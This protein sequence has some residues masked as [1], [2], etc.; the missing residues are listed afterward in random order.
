VPGPFKRLRPGERGDARAAFAVLCALVGSHAILE[1]ARD[2]LFL[3]E[4]PASR[5]PVVYL[6]IAGVSLAI[7]ELQTRFGAGVNL[8]ASLCG[9]TGAASAVTLAF[10]LALPSLGTAGLYALYVWSGVLTTL[11]LVHFWALLGDVFSVTQAKRVYGV[12]GLG[13]VTGAIAGSAAAGAL[14]PRIGPSNLLLVAAGGLALA[15]VA[16]LLLRDPGATAPTSPTRGGLVASARLVWRNPYASRLVALTLV[17]TTALTTADYLFKSAAAAHVE[18]DNLG[19]F[20]AF[21]YLG[22]NVA[23]L[24]VQLLLVGA[25]VRRLGVVGSL[26]ALPA[27]LMLS[28]VGAAV[29]GGLIAAL[30]VKGSEGALKHT[31]H[32]TA[33]ELLFVPLPGGA[34]A[35]VKALADVVGQRGGQ[36]VASLAILG[37]VALDLPA[38]AIAIGVAALAAVWL[39]GLVR[40]R[41]AY[42][43]VFRRRLRAA[44]VAHV[45]EF[46]ELDV[47]SLESLFAALGSD[48]DRE[49]I[50]ALDAL[51]LEGRGPLIPPV[52][53]FHPSLDV[54]RHALAQFTRLGRADACTVIDRLLDHP[55]PGVRGAAIA[56]RSALAPDE[57]LLRARL[58]AEDSDEVRAVISV[59]LIASGAVGGTEAAETLAS[60]LANAPASVHT[61]LAEAIAQRGAEGFDD[62]LVALAASEA[63]RVRTAAARA[64]GICGPPAALPTLVGLLGDEATRPAALEALATLGEAGVAAL[65][66]A[67]ANEG[68]PRSLRWRIPSALAHCAPEA[69]ALRL[70]ERLPLERDGLVRYGCVAAL[71]GLVRRNPELAF[72]GGLLR[73]AIESNLARTYRYVHLRVGLLRG[74]SADPTRRTEGFELLDRLLLDKRAH[75]VDRLFRLLALRYPNEDVRQIARGLQS[76]TRDLRAS[77]LELLE[78]LLRP[79]VREAVVAL[80]DELSDEQRLGAGRRDVEPLEL[81]YDAVLRELLASNSASV[82]TLA[83]YHIG[84]L[85]LTQFHAPLSQLE[86]SAVD[87]GEVRRTLAL[88]G[89]PP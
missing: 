38:R 24:A 76:E 39:A 59:N 60:M 55:E 52:I 5:L 74:A 63:P 57:S 2:A 79:P 6:L 44:Q 22:L 20:F 70:L 34:R 33:T 30:V 41:G 84:E 81:D 19:Q 29:F 47:A 40:L 72:D 9:W 15:A 16:P 48:N 3:V 56:A 50:A 77:S 71:E 49:V 89:S 11:F 23:S 73:E 27:L 86:S 28:G 4:L 65:Q 87:R 78:S 69:A 13:S 64:I 21:T 82:Q 54:V 68:L 14:V 32:R 12:V 36:A 31:V 46:P 8:R 75:A 88:L 26:F 37:V 7:T 35:R 42:V 58:D 10:W 45:G 43:D 61:A 80:V 62:T 17:A 1:T 18:A 66:R 53:V 83:V 67:L 51:E 25:A 85:G